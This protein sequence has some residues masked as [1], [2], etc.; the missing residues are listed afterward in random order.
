MK[1]MTLAV[2]DQK[3]REFASLC[4]QGIDAWIKAGEILV[5]LVED[6]P[7]VFDKIISVDPRMN[8][9]ILGRFE[10]MGRRVLH[11]QLLLSDAPGFE[12]LSQMP[13][14]VQERFINEPIPLVVQTG[15]GT[16]ILLVSAKNLTSNQARQVF[17]KGRVRTEGEQKAWLMDQRA[18][19]A[20]PS[21]TN[22]PA[23]TIRGGRAV[24]AEGAT[25]SAGELAVIIT[26]LSK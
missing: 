10:Q 7:H 25:L 8:A 24:F 3:I 18:R 16:D 15:S 21:G 2:K 1:K 11:P 22:I 9:G 19:K 5:E 4:Q 20:K 17:G 14:S 12:R 6:D 13:Y 26:Q 23:W